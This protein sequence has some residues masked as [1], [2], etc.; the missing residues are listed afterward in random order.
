MT[1]D[2]PNAFVQTNVEYQ[3]ADERI[4]VKIRGPL[5]DMLIKLDP[6]TY[7]DYVVYEGQ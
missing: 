1:I 7:R 5:V 2:I 6:V 3:D 4:I